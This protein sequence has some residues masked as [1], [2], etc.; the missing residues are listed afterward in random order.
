[1]LMVGGM[2]TVAGGVLAGYVAMLQEFNPDI[3]IHL[4]TASVLS[5]PA[6]IVVAKVMIPEDPGVEPETKHGIP[7]SASEKIDSN[8]IEAAA[9]GASEGLKLAINVGG[10]L[11]AF[12]ALIYMA[13]AILVYFGELIGFNLWGSSLDPFYTEGDNAKLTLSVVFSW[14]F[15]PFALLMGI[16]F[17]EAFLAGSLLGQKVALNEFVAY[18]SLAQMGEVFSER[19]FLILSYALCG[20]ANFASIAIQI[21]GVGSLAPERRS[22]LAQMGMKS[23]AGGCLAAFMTACIANIFI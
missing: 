10:M 18:L 7:K 9:R 1:M 14:L 23:V 3:A 4:L 19:T 2:A 16:P 13:D 5:A 12:L 15:F 6:A 8:I 11:L 20:F 21:G 22:D 17:D